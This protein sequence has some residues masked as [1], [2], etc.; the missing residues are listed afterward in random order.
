MISS[1]LF[2]HLNISLNIQTKSFISF[3]GVLGMEK[4]KRWW[5]FMAVLNIEKYRQKNGEDV[6][7][8]ILK[9]TKNFPKGYFYCDSCDEELVRQYT[10]CMYKQRH[11]YVVAVIGSSYNRQTKQFHQEK[12]CN[13]LDEYHDCINH[14]NGV[15]FDNANVNLDVVTNQQNCWARPS[16]GYAILG[17]SFEPYVAVNYQLIYV[18]CVKT[19]VEA[20]IVAHQLELQYEDYMYDFLKD[21]RK[22]IDI[23]DLERTG[24][25]S[26]EESVY[27]HVL[28]YADNAWYVYR[29]NLFDYFNEY[30]IPVPVFS[31][32]SDGFMVHPITGQR[33]CPL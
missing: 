10:W 32:D 11:P 25:I 29:Y 27:K 18:K 3:A 5:E 13:I 7:K 24:K 1:G 28:K 33:L 6:L 12:A 23:L 22:D 14:I 8:V 15:E 19:E 17:K 30:R 4:N 16:R 2:L 21:R 20:C 9:P 26:E 31:I